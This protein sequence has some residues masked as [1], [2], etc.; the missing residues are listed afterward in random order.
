LDAGTRDVLQVCGTGHATYICL[1]V[2]VRDVHTAVPSVFRTDVVS[3]CNGILSPI[4]EVS[5]IANPSGLN[6]VS[7]L[8]IP[9][10]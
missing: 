5:K 1:H 6:D 10:T 8:R 7:V 3:P 9:S 2:S 4:G